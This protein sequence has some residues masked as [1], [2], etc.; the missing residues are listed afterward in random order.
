MQGHAI[1]SFGCCYFVLIHVGIQECWIHD[2]YQPI[3]TIKSKT[4][5]VSCQHS[6]PLDWHHCVQLVG[7]HFLDFSGWGQSFLG[8]NKNFS[9]SSGSR[10]KVQGSRFK[11]QGSRLKAQGPRLKA[12]GSRLQAQGSR[13]K[14]QSSAIPEGERD[15]SEQTLATPALQRMNVFRGVVNM[16]SSER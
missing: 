12:Q 7:L 5:S 2:R 1:V 3:C 15:Y 4:D 16:V 11:A 8:S 9:D 14:A 13:L 6:S 10:F